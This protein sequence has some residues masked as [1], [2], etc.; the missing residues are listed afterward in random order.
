VAVVIVTYNSRHEIGPCLDS[1]VGH[2]APFD[3]SFTVVDNKSTDDTVRFVRQGWPMVQVIEPRANVGFARA[4]NLGIRATR[5]DF[6]VTINPDTV[7]PPGGMQTLLRGL[8]V[9]PEAAIAG[10]RLL[11]DHGFP[12]IS[13]GPPIGPWGELKQKCLSGLY[14]RKVRRVVRYVDRLSRQAREVAWVSGACMAIR[15]ADLEA[16]GLFD[17][18][19]FMYTEDVDL[20]MAMR[21]RGRSVLYVAQA[22]VV[23][24]RGRSAARNPD[25][26]RVRRQS[27]LAYYE[28]HHPAWAPV[29]RGY[30]TLAGKI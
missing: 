19:Y 22:E 6:V 9:H 8:A 24:H 7:T 21:A 10:P 29:L 4:N 12:E 16:V 14:E 28:K 2:T 26:D 30:L 23:H 3:A 20:C 11:N 5:S 1:L 27:Q 13:W 17:E 18:R 25:T 15:R